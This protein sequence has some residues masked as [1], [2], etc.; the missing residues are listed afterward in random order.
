[1]LSSMA[2]RRTVRKRRVGERGKTWADLAF[3][4]LG[5]VGPG[6][7]RALFG[8]AIVCATVYVT[9]HWT[10][11]TTQAEPAATWTPAGSSQAGGNAFIAAGDNGGGSVVLD[12][13]NVRGGDGTIRGGDV[14][15]A[16]G[17]GGPNGPGGSVTVT[18]GTTISGGSVKAGRP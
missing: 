7:R 8:A 9:T 13:A 6:K 10:T 4:V 18:G 2:V 5:K 3:V 12:H 11:S 1:M 15:V 17:A 16:A 14:V